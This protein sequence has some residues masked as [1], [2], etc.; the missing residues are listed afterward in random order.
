MPHLLRAMSLITC[1]LAAGCHGCD[2]MS[3]EPIDNEPGGDEVNVDEPPEQV[4]P[5][6]R[7]NDGLDGVVARDDR[8]EV[9][10]ELLGPDGMGVLAAPPGGVATLLVPTDD[11]FAD[12]PAGCLTVWERDGWTWTLIEHHMV[13]GATRL[14]RRHLV[15]LADNGGSLPM[16]SR[17]EVAVDV[18]GGQL[19]AN[20]HLVIEPLMAS[21]GVIHP[22]SG[23]LLPRILADSLP[24]GCLVDD[25]SP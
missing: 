24:A 3:G 15:E 13:L 25:G 10:A 7:D 20:G 1:L 22:I 5:D 19:M 6:V 17:E 2:E 12:L 18:L 14:E 11:A 16:A 8:L 23:V 4:P 9:F 21:N